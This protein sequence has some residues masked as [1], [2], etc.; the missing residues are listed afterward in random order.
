MK[1][2]IFLLTILVF[3]TSCGIHKN[4]GSGG[5]KPRVEVFEVAKKQLREN[6]RQD[7]IFIS[8][9]KVA[10]TDQLHL[11]I[12]YRHQAASLIG[13]VIVVK[14]VN[15][16]PKITFQNGWNFLKPGAELSNELLDD[17][18]SLFNIFSEKDIA[19]NVE[20]VKA[21]N[22]N[23]EAGVSYNLNYKT[24]FASYPK[25]GDIVD[26]TKLDRVVSK[27][28]SSYNS[29]SQ[30]MNVRGSLKMIRSV[31][32]QR[33]AYQKYKKF[34]TTV[35]ASTLV[36]VN[37]SLHYAEGQEMYEY[38]VI[39]DLVDLTWD[40]QPELKKAA[41]SKNEMIESWHVK[42]AKPIQDK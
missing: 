6:L 16:Q 14:E 38:E 32:V 26:E 36:N 23:L 17:A 22:G 4:S 39:V 27:Y 30:S 18:K 15:G 1:N 3:M 2:Q 41:G 29:Q 5:P 25:P 13:T 24:I 34:D 28:L 40:A 20:A 12:E 19:T 21:A 8:M 35:T 42:I 31:T 7:S 33:L 11:P 10:S 9:T 37:G